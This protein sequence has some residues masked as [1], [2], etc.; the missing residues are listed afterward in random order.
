MKKFSNRVFWF[1][2][3]RVNKVCLWAEADKMADIVGPPV[4]YIDKK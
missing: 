2:Q 1:V 3:V 4:I